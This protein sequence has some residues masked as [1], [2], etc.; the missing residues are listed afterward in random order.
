M[1]ELTV[2]W[3]PTLILLSYGISFVGSYAAVSLCE[4]Y[5]MASIN[6]YRDLYISHPIFF[7][8]LVA[9]SIG[10]VAVW[11]MHFIGMA[12]I[13]LRT[14]N[15]DE[16]H[17]N[18]DI[19]MTVASVIVVVASVFL[20]LYIASRD[21]AYTKTK[22]QIIDMVVCDAKKSGVK[23]TSKLRLIFLS[24]MKGLGVLAFGGLVTSGGVCAMHYLG[25]MSQRFQGHMEWDI[26]VIAASVAIAFVVSIVAFWILFRLLALYPYLEWLRVLS[27]MVMG[28]AVNAM[29]YTGV[30]GAKFYYDRNKNTHKYTNTSMTTGEVFSYA[31]LIAFGISWILNIITMRDMRRRQNYCSS[32]IAK[33]DEIFE[34]AFKAPG[35]SV[36]Q[37]L[38]KYKEARGISYKEIC[39]SVLSE[40]VPQGR[41]GRD[42][43]LAFQ[44]PFSPNVQARMSWLASNSFKF[45]DKNQE[46]SISV[47]RRR[48]GR[49]MSE[50]MPKG[51][52][53][54]VRD[55]QVGASASPS[56]PGKVVADNHAHSNVRTSSDPPMSGLSSP[57]TAFK[58]DE[59][60]NV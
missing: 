55:V 57:V 52:P 44:L 34:K 23:I 5:R 38:T 56:S 29:H 24:S 45:L 40:T 50:K 17:V 4:Q 18:Y 53:M 54:R 10:L 21:R 28:L 32:V 58:M 3:K 59:S 42:E 13:E 14:A 49:N 11:S 6:P 43:A 35:S 37:F 7:L 1:E 20:G 33:T 25:M 2:S 8:A 15:G 26:G 51:S 12:A 36:E 60:Y 16:V 39:V 9:V 30:Y 22:E 19:G 41:M 27:A 31:L 48:L 47:S 46:N